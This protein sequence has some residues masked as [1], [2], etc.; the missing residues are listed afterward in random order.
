[1]NA[2]QH[3][4]A[5]LLD[6]AKAYDTVNHP[7]LLS[8]LHQYGFRDVILNWFRSYLSNRQHSVRIGNSTSHAARTNISIPQG[9]VLG[10][11]LF[12]LYFSD[13]AYVSEVLKPILFAEDTAFIGSDVRFIV[14]L[15]DRFNEELQK[16][17]AWLV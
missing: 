3:T 10:C 2:K 13:V 17:N 14:R 5:V 6:L 11:N 16:I 15:C 8:K 4:I 7:I 12:S 1:M 9:S